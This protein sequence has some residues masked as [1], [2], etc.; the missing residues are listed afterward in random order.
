MTRLWLEH[1]LIINRERTYTYGQKIGG[2]RYA[3][4]TF[5]DIDGN[6]AQQ[7]RRSHVNAT[8]D[9]RGSV[10]YLWMGTQFAVGGSFS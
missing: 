7:I 9:V 4:Y 3:A 2:F 6:G 1:L 5:L 8:Q 10:T